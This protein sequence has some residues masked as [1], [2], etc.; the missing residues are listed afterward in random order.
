VS[1]T[2]EDPV[3]ALKRLN[4]TQEET[5]RFF[6]ALAMA[7]IGPRFQCGGFLPEEAF[8]ELEIHPF[9]SSSPHETGTVVDVVGGGAGYVVAW[10][11][12]D[13]SAG[14]RYT[15]YGVEDL[16]LAQRV[17]VDDAIWAEGAA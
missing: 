9:G 6:D 12:V 5:E 14:F 10:D 4:Y 15:R 13:Y 8:F 3:A 17:T 2:R 16:H 11:S 7:S 1:T